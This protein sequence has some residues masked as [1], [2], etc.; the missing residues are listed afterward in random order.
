MDWHYRPLRTFWWS[1]VCSHTQLSA[2]GRLEWL[3]SCP[4]YYTSRERAHS[5]HHIKGWVD[6][7]AGIKSQF[8]GCPPHSLETVLA[9][10]PSCLVYRLCEMQNNTLVHWKFMC[11]LAVV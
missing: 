10:L 3:A 4:C 9:Y 7:A 11:K 5:S 1:Y 8:S 2:P 6:C